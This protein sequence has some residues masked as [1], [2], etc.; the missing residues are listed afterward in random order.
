M[1]LGT[2]LDR[3]CKRFP[4]RFFDVGIGE[5]FAVNLA[6]GLA[7]GGY[8]PVVA[9]Y[10]TFLQRAFDQ[11]SQE[12]ALQRLPVVFIIDRAGLVGEDGSTHHG[13]FDITYM[14]AIPGMTVMAPRDADE[15]A[16]MLEFAVDLAAPVA[17]RFPRGASP[18]L[19]LHHRTPIEKGKGELLHEGEDVA[20]FAY[21]EMV[22]AALGTR[23]LLREKGISAAVVNARFAKPLDTGLLK[24]VANGKRLVCCLEDNVIPGGFGSAVLESVG[25][26]TG[27]PILLR[28]LPDAFI[29]HGSTAKLLSEARLTPEAISADIEKHLISR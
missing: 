20:L 11:I 5:Q 27:P 16:S 26:A 8:I 4:E 23:E 9:I 14:R 29:H 17:I 21:G 25:C 19:G 10:S 1:K 3:F 15:L 13:Y 2:G 22:S 24:E 6:A 12:V 7:L 18:E 28:G